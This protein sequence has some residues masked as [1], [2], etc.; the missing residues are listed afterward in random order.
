MSDTVHATAS[1]NGATP[2]RPSACCEVAFALA[3]IFTC[4]GRSATG[5]RSC[6][7]AGR[8]FRQQAL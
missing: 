5:G 2:A 4:D 6:A 3:D 8:D 7:A 1:E